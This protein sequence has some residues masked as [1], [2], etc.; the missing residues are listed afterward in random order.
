[1]IFPVTAVRFWTE[2]AIRRWRTRTRPRKWRVP[3]SKRRCL[4]RISWVREPILSQSVKIVME[5]SPAWQPLVKLAIPRNKKVYCGSD[6]IWLWSTRC[7]INDNGEL[8]WRKSIHTIV[9]ASNSYE[10]IFEYHFQNGMT[11]LFQLDITSYQIFLASKP[12]PV[13]LKPAVGRTWNSS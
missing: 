2:A 4:Y 10:I 7:L 12:M 5:F 13:V 8:K 1:M 11:Q 3:N 9:R 6:R